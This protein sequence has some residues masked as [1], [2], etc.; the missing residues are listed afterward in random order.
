MARSSRRDL[1]VNE[2]LAILDAGCHDDT[3]LVSL[4]LDAE[5]DDD[6]QPSGDRMSPD[7][8]QSL[9]P[10]GVLTFSGAF[11]SL[12]L[13]DTDPSHRYSLLLSDLSVPDHGK[14]IRI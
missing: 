13:D 3:E 1:S 4:D 6:E 14:N 2:I 11:Q 5:S 8:T 9:V 10:N 7:G 12:I